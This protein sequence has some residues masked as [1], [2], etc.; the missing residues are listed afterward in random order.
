MVLTG[1]FSSPIQPIPSDDVFLDIES[2]LRFGCE[3]GAALDGIRVPGLREQA[4]HILKFSPRGAQGT[5]E[6][7]CEILYDKVGVYRRK[8]CRSKPIHCR[9]CRG[10]DLHR[11]LLLYEFDFIVERGSNRVVIAKLRD[12]DGQVRSVAIFVALWTLLI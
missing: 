1:C 2:S 4:A 6:N 5:L 9:A 7:R 8:S 11:E 10:G 12:T 3:P